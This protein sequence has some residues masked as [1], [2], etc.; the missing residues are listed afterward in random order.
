MYHIIVSFA[1]DLRTH[2]DTITFYEVNFQ[3]KK[4]REQDRMKED[5]VIDNKKC[6]TFSHLLFNA[7]LTL[8]KVYSFERTRKKNDNADSQ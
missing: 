2:A 6:I 3:K 5:V 7:E 8:E 1:R 4:R